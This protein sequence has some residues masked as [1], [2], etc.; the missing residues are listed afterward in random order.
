MAEIKVIGL[1]EELKRFLKSKASLRGISLSKLV[2]EGLDKAF[3][4]LAKR[5]TKEKT[6]P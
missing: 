3:P 2:I 1:P 4:K 6:K 5:T